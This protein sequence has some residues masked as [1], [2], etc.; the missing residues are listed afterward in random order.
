MSDIVYL[1]IQKN[2]EISKNAVKIGDIAN[3]WCTNAPTANKAKAIKLM[4][5]PNEKKA[6][7]TVSVMKV[8]QL[9]NEQMPNVEVN[10]IGESDFI[11]DYECNK[12]VNLTFNFIKVAVISIITFVGAAYAIMA[13]NNDVGTDDIL[14]RAYG[15]LLSDPQDGHG[16][17]EIMFSVGLTLGIIIFYNHFVGK[18][19]TNDPTPMQVEMNSYETQVDDALINRSNAAGVEKMC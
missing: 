10:N 19:F 17:L 15:I 1:K 14:Q 9:I 13:Y 11:I 12:K 6:R 5:I 2:N 4:N 18:K 8:I 16:I 7:Y 3:I